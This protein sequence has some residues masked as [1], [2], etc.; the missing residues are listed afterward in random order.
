MT[1]EKHEDDID[2]V[3]VIANSVISKENQ[4]WQVRQ[5]AVNF[6]RCFQGSHRMILTAFQT[7]QVMDI[8]INMLANDRREVSS[9]AQIAITG[10]IAGAPIDIVSELVQK[11]IKMAKQSLPVKK[12]KKKLK[13]KSGSTSNEENEKVRR[14][15]QQTSVL[16]LCA[17]V[18]SRP[19]DTPSHVPP[20][21]A[22]LSKHSFD[23]SSSYVVRQAV[24]NCC[25]EYKKTHMSENNWELHR[26]KFTQEE[27]ESLED[28]VSTP[29]YY[30]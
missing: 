28:V 24:K 4:K 11:F 27:L 3:L 2:Q 16:F 20:A 17:C 14:T 12:R 8:L 30:A 15:Q 1:H 18:L 10:I 6:L 13:E 7:E 29:H 21:L 22:A 26:Q 5:V 19:Y 23:T 9:A 25:S